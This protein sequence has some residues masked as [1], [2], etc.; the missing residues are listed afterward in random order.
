MDVRDW[1]DGLRVLGVVGV[2]SLS[3]LSSL[4]TPLI[5]MDKRGESVTSFGCGGDGRSVDVSA[6]VIRRKTGMSMADYLQSK[7]KSTVLPIRCDAEKQ[8]TRSQPT[9]GSVSSPDKR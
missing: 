3:T 8:L 9:V 2:F 1:R 7:S 5:S 4:G 6:I